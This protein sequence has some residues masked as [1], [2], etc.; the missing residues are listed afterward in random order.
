MLALPAGFAFISSVITPRRAD[1]VSQHTESDYNNRIII[2][3]IG[4][5]IIITEG[6]EWPRLVHHCLLFFI[7]FL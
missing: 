7:T 2:I 3:F 6:S 4:A 5:L 1:G